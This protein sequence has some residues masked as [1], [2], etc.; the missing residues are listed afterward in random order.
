MEV[1]NVS[2]KQ[3]DKKKKSGSLPTSCKCHYGTALGE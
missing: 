3:N 1:R 2:Q